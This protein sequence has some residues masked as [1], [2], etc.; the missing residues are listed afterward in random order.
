MNAMDHLWAR[1]R[2]SRDGHAVDQASALA[3]EYLIDL[4]HM[5]AAEA[6]VCRHFC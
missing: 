3:L 1:E 6:G 2:D 5:T 4:A